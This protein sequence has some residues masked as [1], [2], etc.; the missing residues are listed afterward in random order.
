MDIC[1]VAAMLGYLVERGSSPGPLFKLADGPYLTRNRFESRPRECGIDPALYAGYSFRIRAA[2]T[3]ALRGVQD[4]LI[5]TLGRWDSSAYT[6]YIHT[7]LH[8]HTPVHA[9]L[10]S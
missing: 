10:G 1:P 3:A 9:D 8:P 4:S 5:K 7:P 2:T 6:T